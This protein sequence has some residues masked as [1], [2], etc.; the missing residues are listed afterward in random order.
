MPKAVFKKLNTIIILKNEVVII[1]IDGA[2]DKIVSSNNNCSVT[3]KSSGLSDEPTFTPIL[4][5]AIVCELCAKRF[6][7]NE[8]NEIAKTKMSKYFSFYTHISF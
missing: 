1:I 2:K 4:G 6:S 8:N 7:S 3:A 5:I